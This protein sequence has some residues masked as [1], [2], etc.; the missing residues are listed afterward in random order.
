MFTARMVVIAVGMLAGSVWVGSL[1]CL[2]LVARVA[3]RHLD[4]PARVSLFRAIGRLYAVVGT[5]ALVVAIAVGVVLAWP[6]PDASGTV[7]TAL[8][9]AGILVVLTG[10]GMAQARRMTLR[11][12]H[13]LG[14]PRDP[15]G[16]RAVARGATAAGALRGAMAAVTFVI[17]V[18]GAHLL[19]Q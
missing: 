13:V 11:R 12:Q 14:A 17:V 6:L 7:V 15:D 8:V 18:L 9:L 5:G 10:A 1:V 3:S 19:D 4:G 16:Q 2:A